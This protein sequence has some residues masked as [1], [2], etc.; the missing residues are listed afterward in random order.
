VHGS[1]AAAPIGA[2]HFINGSS[3]LLFKLIKMIEHVR[4]VTDPGSASSEQLGDSMLT[5]PSMH[6]HATS[7]KAHEGGGVGVG[8]G[9]CAT[10]VVVV[11]TK[12]SATNM[13]MRECQSPK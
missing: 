13:S 7:L 9:V 8:A 10:V 12:M 2:G 5:R 11:T 1:P 3:A 4:P 6:G